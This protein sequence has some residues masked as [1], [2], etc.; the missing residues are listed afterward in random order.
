M[1]TLILNGS[2]RKKGVTTQMLKIMEEKAREKGTVEHIRI[3]DCDIT[4]CA[5][6]M[7]C[8]P[9]KK[10]LLPQDDGHR[11][12]RLID[13]ADLLILSSPTYW[14]NI[15]GPLKTVLD[16]CVTTFEYLDGHRFPKRLQKGKRALIVTASSAPI[17]YHL[18]PSQSNGAVRAMK[19]V[20]KAGG[21]NIKGVL[22]IPDSNRFEEKKEGFTLQAKGLVN[23][24]LKG[25]SEPTVRR[26]PH[27]KGSAARLRRQG[28]VL[29]TRVG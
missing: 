22:N 14:G 7:G 4:P 24:A 17:G 6:C 29:R 16:R 5:G 23:R 27:E 1:K 13:E 11:I 2:P 21:Y 12:A 3:Y 9:D 26:F 19:T 20:L 28:D 18:L 8:R 25:Y 10:C 15:S